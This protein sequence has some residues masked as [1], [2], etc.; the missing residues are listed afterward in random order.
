MVLSRFWLIWLPLILLGI[1]AALE[2]SFST[3]KLSVLMSENG[4]VELLQ[5]MIMVLASLVATLTL[6]RIN[7]CKTPWV[8]AWVLIALL[9]CLYVAGEEVSWG[10]HFLNWNTPAY[11]QGINDQH[12]TNLHN[13]SSWLDQKP[14]LILLIGII[15]GGLLFPLLDH[16][17]PGFLPE[18]F[19]LVY[20]PREL[21]LIALLV[22]GPGIAN[23]LAKLFDVHLFE[24]VSEV[25]EV[26]MF[27]FVLLY[28]IFLKRRIFG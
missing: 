7:P 21:V 4:P 28:L 14:R 22:V 13:V 15:V 9:S 3:G 25:Q 11:W 19:S 2:V 26:Y 23:D 12:E 1:Q 8:F 20:P 27:Y 10:Q 6:V 16:V 18:R 5:W 17:R 24:R